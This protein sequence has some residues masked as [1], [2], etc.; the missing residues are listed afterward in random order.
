MSRGGTSMKR[1]GAQRNAVKAFCQIAAA[2]IAA[3][4]GIACSGSPVDREAVAAAPAET[5]TA[6][7]VERLYVLDCGVE[8]AADQSRW[9]VGFNVGKPID[10]SVKCYLI[11]HKQGYLLWD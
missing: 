1:V 9:T 3:C 10:I 6:T 11:K 5:S 2:V 4:F 7:G 8:H